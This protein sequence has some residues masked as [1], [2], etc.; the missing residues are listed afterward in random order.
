MDSQSYTT[1][2]A[3]VETYMYTDGF[4]APRFCI[5]HVVDGVTV[6]VSML[7]VYPSGVDPPSVTAYLLVY[8]R[9]AS[10]G[11][12]PRS[13][14]N[15]GL[16]SRIQSKNGRKHWTHI[17]TRSVSLSIRSRSTTSLLLP[18]IGVR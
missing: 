10:S 2:H 15:M 4:L 17:L 1:G 8:R 13:N 12:M 16:S 11:C 3:E 14:K 7:A 5:L 6:E 18:P 9:I